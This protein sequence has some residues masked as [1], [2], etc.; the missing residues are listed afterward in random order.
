MLKRIRTKGV[1]LP[2]MMTAVG[3]TVIMLAASGMIFKA[4]SHSSGKAMALNDMMAKVRVVTNRLDKD[5]SGF[6]GDM[7]FGVVFEAYKKDNGT[8]ERRDRLF[9]FS[10]G[11]FQSLNS[12]QRAD[13]ALIC[14]G[15]SKDIFSNANTD[16]EIPSDDF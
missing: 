8:F 10:N 14:Y 12:S 16:P 6:R 5:F 1:T 4:A 2:E 7:P 15:Q 3:I 9:F 11:D 13:M